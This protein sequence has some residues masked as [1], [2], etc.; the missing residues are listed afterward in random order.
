MLNTFNI[1]DGKIVEAGENVPQ[2]L[3]YT[4]PDETEKNYLINNFSIDEHNLNSALDPD[5]LGRLE[6]ENSHLVAIVK[7]PR[8]FCADDNFLLKISSLGLF[9]YA[10]KLIIITQDDFLFEGRKFLKLLSVQDVF[11]KVIFAI[12]LH[13]EGHLKVIQQISNELETEINQAVSNKDLFSM[14]NLEKSLVYYLNT[15]N[16][17][18]KVIEK[19]KTNSVKIGFSDDAKEFLEDVII[20][21]AQCYEQAN[22]YSQVLSSMMDAWASIINNNLNIRIKTL[23]ILSICIMTPT[24]IV[25]FFSMNMPLPIPQVG[26]LSS[27]WFVFSLAAIAELIIV[28]L[29]RYQK[30]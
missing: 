11:L 3:V 7:R 20:E 26:T 1:I 22:T 21:N 9:L 14:F 25:S 19:L 16:S 23:T 4:K 17:N 10:D 2:I 5:E 6:F 13:F 27:F 8:T 18:G 30:L 24:L 29:W 15:I 12:I 28:L